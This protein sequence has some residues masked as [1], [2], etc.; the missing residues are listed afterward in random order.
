[1]GRPDERAFPLT[2]LWSTLTYQDFPGGPV[3]KNLPTNAEDMSSITGP[4]RFHMLWATKPVHRGYRVHALEPM[5]GNK[6]SHHNEKPPH[7][8]EQ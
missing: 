1:M 3:V 2:M 6:R 5:L 4:G 8:K 7:C